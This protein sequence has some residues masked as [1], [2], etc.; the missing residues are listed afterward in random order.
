M[1]VN[2]ESTIVAVSMSEVCDSNVT[3]L[4]VVASKSF[5][6]NDVIYASVIVAFVIVV[7]VEVKSVIVAVLTYA[8][9]VLTYKTVPELSI[10]KTPLTVA[11]LLTV[12]FPF[13]LTFPV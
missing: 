1:F 12:K 6:S 5:A 13:A 8:D 9:P 2:V 11:L 10:C 3:I 7:F 4:P